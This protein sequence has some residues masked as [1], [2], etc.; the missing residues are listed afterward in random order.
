MPV[1]SLDTDMQR[2][3]A[4][5]SLWPSQSLASFSQ[6]INRQEQEKNTC[7]MAVSAQEKNKVGRETKDCWGYSFIQD[8]QERVQK[9]GRA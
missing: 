7:W 2:T 5:K 9:K 6:S 3:K 4:D 8:S 1:I